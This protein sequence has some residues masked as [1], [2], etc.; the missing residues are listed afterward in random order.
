MGRKNRN[1]IRRGDTFYFRKRVN[2]T[3]IKK[4]LSTNLTEARKL[5]DSF[6]KDILLYGKIQE[7]E[8]MTLTSPDLVFGE[9]SKQW[10]EI[11]RKEIRSSTLTDYR[12]AMNCH[13]LPKIGNVPINELGFLDVQKMISGMTCSGKRLKNVLTPVREV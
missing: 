7:P 4:A 13:V 5:R 10:I 2:G 8:P 3:L 12:S 9:I 11:K 1:L 6:L